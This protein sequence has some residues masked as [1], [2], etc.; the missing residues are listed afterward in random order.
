ML[1]SHPAQLAL[2]APFR[3]ARRE[4][5]FSLAPLARGPQVEERLRHPLELLLDSPRAL[6]ALGGAVPLLALGIWYCVSEC[7]SE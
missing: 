7:V 3:L 1:Q 5:A 4:R 6:T 2:P